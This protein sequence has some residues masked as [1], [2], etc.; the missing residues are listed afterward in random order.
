MRPISFEHVREVFLPYNCGVCGKNLLTNG[1]VYYGLCPSCLR[2]FTRDPL[3]R[4]IFCGRPLLAE[5]KACLECRT[6]E[7]PPSIHAAAALFP[8][9][10]QAGSLMRTY[11][12]RGQRN[13]SRYIAHSFNRELHFLLHDIDIA[14]INIVQVPSSPGK[15]KKKAW[16]QMEL[17]AKELALKSG[18]PRLNCLCRKKSAVQKTLNR[19]EREA[20]L[21]GKIYCKGPAPLNALLID[22]VLTTG[23]TMRACAKILKEAGS[24]RIY[25]LSFCY[26]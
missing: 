16:D 15:K 9:S 6:L 11:K 21:W 25:C 7:E 2:F 13:L 19:L 14:N 3:P 24:E 17:V 20:N 1:L 23:A 26:D 4:C 5:K 8:Y 10:A 18:I 12:F 22:D